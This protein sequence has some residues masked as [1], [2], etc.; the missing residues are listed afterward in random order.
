MTEDKFP[1]IE[2]DVQGETGGDGLPELLSPEQLA[3]ELEALGQFDALMRLPRTATRRPEGAE[4]YDAFRMYALLGFGRPTLRKFYDEHYVPQRKSRNLVVREFSTM[5]Q[6]LRYFHWGDRLRKFDAEEEKRQII[7]HRWQALQNRRQRILVW[8]NFL[9][10]TIKAMQVLSPAE[11]SWADVT[12][13]LVAASHNLRTE[14]GDDIQRAMVLFAN[15][16]GAPSAKDDPFKDLTDAE[17][18]QALIN[19]RAAGQAAGGVLDASVYETGE[20]RD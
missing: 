17:I 20:P 4:A 5:V 11:A 3:M 13:A 15:A 1:P 18:E 16:D 14:Y 6:W 12:R 7:E 10:K 2:D 9:A 8:Q 19:I